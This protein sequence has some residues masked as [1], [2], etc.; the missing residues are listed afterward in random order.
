MKKKYKIILIV[1]II[2]LVICISIPLY[3]YIRIKTAKIEVTLKDD[4]TAEFNSDIKVSDYITSINGKIVDDYK[5]DTTK[6]GVKNIEF[7]FINDDN[8]KLKYNYDIQIV[9]TVKPLVWL[10][11]TYSV[12]K[13]SNIDLTEAILCGDNYDSNPNCYIEGNYDLS[14]V[15]DY[16]LVFKAEDSSGNI[17]EVNFTL[18]V[19]EPSSTSSSNQSTTQ[20][21]TYFND[22]ISNYK[23]QNNKIGI[24]ISEWQ[25]D[26]D[27]DKLK[28][29]GVEFIMIRVG[30]SKGKDGEYV[31]DEKF[32]QNIK[33][34]NKANIPVGVYFYSY[35]DS[36][37]KAQ[38]D[39]RWVLKQIKGYDI[40]LPIA[41][42]WEEWSSFNKY[43]LSFFG[44]TN[45]AEDFFKVVE[46]S[47]YKGMLYS[48]K[49]YLENIW[50]D[51]D[52]DIWLAHYTS[53]TNYSKDYKMWQ[54]CSDGKV[55]GIYG[56]VDID[57]L[58]N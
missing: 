54:L 11:N 2:I 48:S 39:A 45:M 12:R 18:S 55:D 14:V 37:K 38:K 5:I 13:D 7:D 8:I 1:L 35:A 31:L 52:Y 16:P 49:T 41:F 26:V 43:H 25:G 24:D 22:V 40:D 15:G 28:E 53:Q 19:Y 30:Y 32:K 42:D 44:L 9:D 29:S 58:Y 57:I 50:F 4:M 20:S 47:G 33:G 17:K 27:F 56:N 36:S 21:H 6:L 3:N 51:T 46:K 10:S 23:T 34:A